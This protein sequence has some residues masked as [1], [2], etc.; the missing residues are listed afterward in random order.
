MLDHAGETD[1]LPVCGCR[2]PLALVCLR[3]R[4]AGLTEDFESGVPV[5]LNTALGSDGQGPKGFSFV[6]L[7]L[8]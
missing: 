1:R 7:D 4:G 8:F 2:W 5:A 3:F 6:F